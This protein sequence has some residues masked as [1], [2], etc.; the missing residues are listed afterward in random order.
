MLRFQKKLKGQVFLL[1]ILLLSS[2][3]VMGIT[4]I[5][6]STRDLKLAYQSSESTK[7]LYAADSEMERLL[8]WTLVEEKEGETPIVKMEEGTSCGGD[9]SNF[10]LSG[11]NSYLST[12]GY[13]KPTLE[14][15][16]VARGME[17]NFQVFLPSP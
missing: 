7:A 5:I 12:T 17:I 11:P 1:S 8:Y 16:T 4:L 2:I 9:A 13:N 3:L 14:E 10:S 6:I 15:S